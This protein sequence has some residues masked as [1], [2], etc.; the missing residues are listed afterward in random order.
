MSEPILKKISC[1]HCY[2]EFYTTFY[3]LVDLAKEKEKLLTGLREIA[4]RAEKA[5]AERDRL[6]EECRRFHLETRNE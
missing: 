4:K 5:E 6:M 1:P 3:A 2:G